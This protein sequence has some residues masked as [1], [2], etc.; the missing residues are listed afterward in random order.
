ALEI[1][2]FIF[3]NGIRGKSVFKNV[4]YKSSEISSLF[5]ESFPLFLIVFFDMYI[6]S[7]TKFAIDMH[8]TDVDSGFFNL[9][10][11][12]TYATYLLMNLFM[13]PFLTPLS[14]AYY[15][16]KK[17]YKKLIFKSLV[18]GLVITTVFIL[19]TILFGDIY[20]DII[21]TFT[22][23][24]YI[25]YGSIAKTIL[26]IVVGAGCFYT[27]VTPMYYMLILEGKQAELCIS[28]IITFILSI[29]ISNLFVSNMGLK[30]AAYGALT[31]MFILFTNILITKA[32]NNEHTR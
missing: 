27:I 17:L 7:S 28:Y 6:I 25:D 2:A 30:G 8:M 11:M 4:N 20:I 3:L 24:I 21:N 22:D 13:K 5:R 26:I 31:N 19:G 23:K 14:N 15:H 32:L 1:I 10:Y 29:F 9:I 18:V 12:P 16:D